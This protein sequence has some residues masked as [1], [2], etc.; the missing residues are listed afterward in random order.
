M[1]KKRREDGTRRTR[2][3]DKLGGLRLKKKKK[4][5]H[6]TEDNKVINLEHV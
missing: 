1:W 6:V 4:E 3:R 2:V 5:A